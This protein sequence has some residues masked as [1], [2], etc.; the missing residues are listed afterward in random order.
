MGRIVH[1]VTLLFSLMLSGCGTMCNLAGAAIP[2]AE[3]A[4]LPAIYG[5]VQIDMAFIN[6]PR[7][8]SKGAAE[9]LCWQ[10]ADVPF[11]F[12]GDTLTLPITIAIDR[13]R[14]PAPHSE[15]PTT[16][17]F[18]DR[19]QYPSSAQPTGRDPEK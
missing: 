10:L 19:T 15:P 18:V 5:G 3:D 8:A 12:V 13:L 2:G 14:N 9:F 1:S 11:S 4:K 6:M 16:S 17:M 7:D